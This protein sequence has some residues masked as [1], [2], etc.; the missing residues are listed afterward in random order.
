MTTPRRITAPPQPPGLGPNGRP[1][2]RWCSAEVPKG[3]RSWCSQRCV[4]EYTAT[5]WPALKRAVEKRDRGVC[6]RCG[7][8]TA[9]QQRAF[10]AWLNGPPGRMPYGPVSQQWLAFHGL[11]TD[12]AMSVWFDVDHVVPLADGGTNTLDNLRTLCVPCH[13]AITSEWRRTRTR[14]AA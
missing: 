14:R 12:R 3:S 4:D 5:T 8:D 1:F 10:L 9:A 2:C 13:R 11:P 7:R 6:Q